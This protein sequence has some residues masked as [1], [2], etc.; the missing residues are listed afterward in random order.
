MATSRRTSEVLRRH[1]RAA[2]ISTFNA[3]HGE[4][5]VTAFG[6]TLARG[7]ASSRAQATAVAPQWGKKWF[8][9][10]TMLLCARKLARVEWVSQSVSQSTHQHNRNSRLSASCRCGQMSIRDGHVPSRQGRQGSAAVAAVGV[11]VAATA[12]CALRLG[13]VSITA[14]KS[15]RPRAA[16]LSS[17]PGSHSCIQRE[18]L[19]LVIER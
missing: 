5:R 10:S 18:S 14:R 1:S 19:V 16:P 2:D 4:S 17:R 13:R 6:P 15:S 9:A 3:R 12:M 7:R 11:G 8:P